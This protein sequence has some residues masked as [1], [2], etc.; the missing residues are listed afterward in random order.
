MN[1][2][3]QKPQNQVGKLLWIETYI[4]PSSAIIMHEAK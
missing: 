4:G 2:L 1:L 3:L